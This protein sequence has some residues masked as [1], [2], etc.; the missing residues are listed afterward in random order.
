MRLVNVVDITEEE[1][2]KNEYN[3]AIFCSGF[4]RRAISLAKRLDPQKIS[5]P[6]I[7]GFIE[8]K[9]EINRIENDEFY[10]L[11]FGLSPILE[12]KKSDKSIYHQLNSLTSKFNRK[13]TLFVD[14][15]SMPRIWYTAILNW[16]MY[17]NEFKTVTI[18]FGYSLAEY[19]NGLSLFTVDDIMSLPGFEGGSISQMD[20]TAIFGLGFDGSAAL[21]V[22]DKL[23]PDTT[24][25]FY[26]KPG[27]HVDYEE[28]TLAENSELIDNVHGR[29]IALPITSVE[30]TFRYLGE[31]VSVYKNNSHITFVPMGPKPHVLA[32]LLV[33]LRFRMVTCLYVSGERQKNDKKINPSELLTT[34]R[35]TFES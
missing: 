24:L 34:T 35:V 7:F 32:S 26:A 23:E 10:K 22:F 6:L 12:S 17:Q 16:I 30:T 4:E 13:L 31:L 33:G 19:Q 25:A 18:D 20:N 8:G 5:H 14:Y 29:T 2:V 3:V 15:S 28:K 21:S 11:K 27:K 1:V 9:N